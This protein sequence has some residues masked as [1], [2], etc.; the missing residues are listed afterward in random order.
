MSKKTINII[1][2]RVQCVYVIKDI[3]LENV[4]LEKYTVKCHDNIDSAWGVTKDG[5][6]TFVGDGSKTI[7]VTLVE[8]ISTIKLL[9]KPGIIEI[10]SKSSGKIIKDFTTQKAKRG[11]KVYIT[12]LEF[13]VEAVK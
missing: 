6:E 11:N 7:E 10:A 1:G 8:K 4:I 3:E 12:E 9:A 5:Q 13:F 2:Q